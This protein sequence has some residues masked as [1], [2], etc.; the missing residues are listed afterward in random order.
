M[1][2]SNSVKIVVVSLTHID[3]IKI[4]VR[5]TSWENANINQESPVILLRNSR[6]TVFDKISK[7]MDFLYHIL[8]NS[9]HPA[10]ALDKRVIYIVFIYYISIVL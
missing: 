8:E 2:L 3:N 5:N 9:K 1:L 7:L 4:W 6:I 10:E